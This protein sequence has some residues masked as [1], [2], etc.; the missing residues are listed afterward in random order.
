M[1]L[2]PKCG[3]DIGIG[4]FCGKCGLTVY[5]NQKNNASAPA[6]KIS[7]ASK[8]EIT[9]ADLDKLEIALRKARMSL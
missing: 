9:K 4:A 3:K 2:C 7:A 1:A 6:G 8:I 5:E